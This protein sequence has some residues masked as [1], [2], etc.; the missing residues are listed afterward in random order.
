M[1]EETEP[2]HSEPPEPAASDAATEASV[3]KVLT[4]LIDAGKIKVVGEEPA[5]APASEPAPKSQADVA[6]R[7][8]R[9]TLA[10]LKAVGLDR[11]AEPASEPAK[12]DPVT[13]PTTPG[14]WG[15]VRKAMWGDE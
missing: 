7:M 3:R 13:P 1:G 15:S 2:V 8:E 11:K 14:F 10:A 6:E 5:K 12:P 4:E 9:I